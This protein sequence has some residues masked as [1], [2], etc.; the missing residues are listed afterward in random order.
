MAFAFA[1]LLLLL[2]FVSFVSASPTNYGP[3]PCKANILVVNDDGWAV[4]EIRSEF[5]AIVAEGYNAILSCPAVDKS[6]TGNSTATPEVLTQ[7]CEFDTC[8]V[9]SP[10]IGFNASD[11]RLNYVNAFPRDATNYGINTLAPRFFHGKKPDLVVG[12]TNI[13]TNL[14]TIIQVSGTDHAAM[15]S[16]NL[17]VPAV[18][19]SASSGGHVSYTELESNPKSPNITAT[20]IYNVLTVKFVDTLLNNT[21]N[22]GQQILPPGAVVNVNYPA[23]TNC[24]S[25]DQFK[26]VFTRTLP[27]PDGTKDVNICNNGGI[28]TDEQTAFDMPGCWATVSVFSSKTLGDVDAKTQQAVVNVLDPLLSCQEPQQPPTSTTP[29]RCPQTQKPQPPKNSHPSY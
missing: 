12:G 2:P 26:W 3:A 21:F 6:G 28:L 9:G 11:P 29:D 24:T 1:K 14:G 7:P 19:F 8:P 22:K 18:A 20:Q 23:I 16:V 10:A 25:P 17:G 15:E 13:G 27:A 5:D 4:A